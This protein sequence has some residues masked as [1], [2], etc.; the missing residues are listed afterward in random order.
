LGER[1]RWLVLNKI[2]LLLEEE[3]EA[4][5]ERIVEALNWQGKVFMVSAAANIGTKDLS[6]QIMQYLDEQTMQNEPSSHTVYSP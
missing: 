2:D 1:E 5:C 4:L 3:R 6:Y